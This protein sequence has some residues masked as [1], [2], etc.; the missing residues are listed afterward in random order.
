M[1]NHQKEELMV[2]FKFS[3]CEFSKKIFAK[4]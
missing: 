4:F 1:D 2:N 3:I